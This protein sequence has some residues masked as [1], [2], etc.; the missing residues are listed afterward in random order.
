MFSWPFNEYQHCPSDL[1]TEFFIH[2]EEKWYIKT[3][4]SRVF[5]RNALTLLSSRLLVC[6][7]KAWAGLL[8]LGSWK[9]GSLLWINIPSSSLRSLPLIVCHPSPH[10]SP[11]PPCSR[12]H[13]FPFLVIVGR[14]S[15]KR[16]QRERGLLSHTTLLSMLHAQEVHIKKKDP[17][18]LFLLC[19]HSNTHGHTTVSH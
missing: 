19:I 7:Y 15:L 4:R 5:F 13:T 2:T 8:F 18:S 14:D 9:M 12:L 6:P 17:L 11:P 10:P 3:E 1:P 16:Q